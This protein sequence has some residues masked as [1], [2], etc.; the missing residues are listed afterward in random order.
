MEFLLFFGP[1][2]PTALIVILVLALLIFGKRLPEVAKSMGKG[3]VEFKKGMKGIE[4][5]I[6]KPIPPPS[7]PYYPQNQYQQPYG[8][9]QQQ[10]QYGQGQSQPYSYQ[11]PPTQQGQ[12]QN[13]QGYQGGYTPP[14]EG[15]AG[16]GAQYGTPAQGQAPAVPPAP[17]S[18]QKPKD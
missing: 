14:Q 11:Q 3:I 6:E 4:D 18:D 10:Q 7:Q 9:Q 1:V 13:P 2:S 17:G 15:S 8:Q 16:Y 5:D 12:A